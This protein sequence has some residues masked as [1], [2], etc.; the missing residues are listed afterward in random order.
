MLSAK[1]V[2]TSPTSSS[3]AWVNCFAGDADCQ[4]LLPANA[5]DVRATSPRQVRQGWPATLAERIAREWAKPTFAPLAPPRAL[6]SSEPGGGDGTASGRR[7][8]RDQGEAGEEA[9]RCRSRSNRS[10]RYH[11]RCSDCSQAAATVPPPALNF[12]EDEV[13]GNKGWDVQG[14]AGPLA[15]EEGLGSRKCSKPRRLAAY[16]AGPLGRLSR[17]AFG[18]LV[19]AVP[20]VHSKLA[21]AC[22]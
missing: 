17:S 19:P 18:A 11:Y 10:S 20:R 5:R 12:D 1:R 4:L 14:A 8:G 7:P 15:V 9:S 6:L 2:T 22:R 3:T 13:G 16:G 21:A